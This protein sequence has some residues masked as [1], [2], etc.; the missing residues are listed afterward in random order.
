MIFPGKQKSSGS[1]RL[2]LNPLLPELFDLQGF[3]VR[4][5][6]KV[7]N[8]LYQRFRTFVP[9]N[10]T[11]DT[12]TR[13]WQGGSQGGADWFKGF[14]APRYADFM[15]FFG[16]FATVWLLPYWKVWTVENCRNVIL[17][18]LSQ[19]HYVRKNKGKKLGYTFWNQH[20]KGVKNQ[21]CSP[22]YLT[23]MRM[24]DWNTTVIFSSECTSM[25]SRVCSIS[26]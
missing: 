23:L 18:S 24:P 20:L 1:K 4:K 19:L 6:I 13:L 16:T 26:E 7:R 22:I 12:I 25:K 21:K 8:H 15:R 2:I 9:C 3:S 14:K 5:K 17:D 10:D 11:L